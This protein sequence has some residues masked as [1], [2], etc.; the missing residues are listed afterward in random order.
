MLTLSLLTLVDQLASSLRDVVHVIVVWNLAVEHAWKIV[1][2][3]K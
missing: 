2:V 3:A 1:S